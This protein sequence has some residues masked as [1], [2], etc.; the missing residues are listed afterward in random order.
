MALDTKKSLRNLNIYQVFLRQHPKSTFNGLKSDLERIK[1]L[2][3]DMVYLCPFYPIGEVNRKGSV[4]SPYSIK[5]YKAID[6]V[7][8]TLDDFKS[9]INEAHKMGLKVMI[10][11]VFNHAA[12]D[13]IKRDS[14]PEW[15]YKKD[16]VITTK[17]PDW[18][19]V[20]DFDFSKPE[21][22]KYLL[23]VLVFYAKLGVDG[24]RCDVASLVPLEFWREAR[25]TTKKINPEIIFLAES[26]Y[27]SFVKYLRDQGFETHSD[28]QLYEVFDILYDYDILDDLRIYLE[29]KD[30]NNWLKAILRQESIYPENYIKLRNLDNHDR[31]RIASMVTDKDKLL[32]LTALSFFLKGATM[33][34]MGQEYGETKRPTLFEVDQVNLTPRNM[35]IRDLIHRMGHLK[36]DS[37]FSTG[38]FNIHFQDKEVAVISY[39]NNS[40]ITYGIF[41]LGLEKGHIKIDI[42]DNVY[43]NILYPNQV[44]VEKGKLELTKKPMILFSIKDHL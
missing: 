32:N 14:N 1:S 35:E 20:I 9:F 13:N 38:I 39:E 42:K 3:M 29:T 17:V 12:H 33:I 43:Q 26:I 7:H 10:D 16:G 36:K 23:D 11:I 41:N 24:F 8:G 22:H 27:L 37:L 31:K 21:V 6:P 5:D 15:F 4:G 2:G 28:S 19:D 25:A 44:K 30:L 40:S 34:Y 18:S